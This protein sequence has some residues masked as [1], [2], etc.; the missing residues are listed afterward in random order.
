MGR[1]ISLVLG[2]LV[3]AIVVHLA[4]VWV[5]PR[6]I[7][8]RTIDR[9]G[10]AGMNEIHFGK[11]PDETARGVVRPSPDLLYSTC[12]YD[13]SAGLLR[14]RSPVPNDTYWSVSLFDAATNNYYVLN[15]RQVYARKS[16]IVDLVIVPAGSDENTENLTRVESPSTKGLVLF[17][18]LINNDKNLAA[19]DAL[20][21]EATCGIWH[22][23][24]QDVST[25]KG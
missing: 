2:T 7:M 25:K 5:I 9:I 18:T 1:M 3:V 20:R 4:S 11:R 17:R 15:D 6:A 14:V 21:R 22:A 8:Y 13:L 16:S 10:S 12:A 23:S 19:I 24:P